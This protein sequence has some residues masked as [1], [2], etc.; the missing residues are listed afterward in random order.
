V[1][2]TQRQTAWPG[3]VGLSRA[4]PGLVGPGW[5]RLGGLAALTQRPGR[6]ADLGRNALHTSG[7]VSM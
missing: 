7:R 1:D 2:Y 4:G 6:M 3:G 5:A